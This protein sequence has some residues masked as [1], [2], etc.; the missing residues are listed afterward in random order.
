MLS[1]QYKRV[2]P[3]GLV[4][5]LRFGRTGLMLAFL[6]TCAMLNISVLFSSLYR[7][8][9][10]L[11]SEPPW[12]GSKPAFGRRMPD[13]LPSN[14]TSQRSSPRPHAEPQQSTHSLTHLFS[15][16][17]SPA[18]TAVRERAQGQAALHRKP[19][20]SEAA[21]LSFPEQLKM[22]KAEG[23]VFFQFQEVQARVTR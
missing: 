8:V 9:Y 21:G 18:R 6:C 14:T 19:E 22:H 11:L 15:R 3:S 4:V 12:P 20:S 2:R 16:S 17:R 1:S 5:A 7:H 23:L 10:R 13:L